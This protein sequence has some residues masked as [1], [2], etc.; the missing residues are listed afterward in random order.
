[1]S[2]LFNFKQIKE[3]FSRKDFKMCF[4]GMHGVSGPYAQ[5]IFG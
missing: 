2:S 1:M 5:R 4:D 3:L